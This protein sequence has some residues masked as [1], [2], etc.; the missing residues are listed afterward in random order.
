MPKDLI[1]FKVVCRSS[2]KRYDRVTLEN[3][4]EI[5]AHTAGKMAEPYSRAKAIL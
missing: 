2:A 1:E 3:E 4:H 5:L